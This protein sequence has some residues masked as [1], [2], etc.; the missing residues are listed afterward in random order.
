VVV[1][2][3]GGSPL[4]EW[5]ADEFRAAHPEQTLRVENVGGPAAL[6]RLRDEGAAAVADVWL[7]APTWIMAR[8]AAEGLLAPS[9]PSW[10]TDLPDAMRDPQD[11]WMGWTAD[12]MVLAFN[13]DKTSRSRAPRDWID[14]FHPRWSV[15]VL[16]PDAA[17]SPTME[18]FVG[19][20]VA[21]MSSP[22]AGD[23]PGFDWLA[24]LDANRKGYVAGGD[25]ALRLGRGEASLALLSLSQAQTA[26]EDGGPVDFR[27]PE[28]G[29]PTLVR[30]V[31]AV[32]GGPHPA[33]A[34]TFMEWLGTPA[35]RAALTKRFRVLPAT[36]GAVEGEPPWVTELRPLLR[37]DVAPADTLAERLGGWLDRW[38]EE[39]MG[40]TPLVF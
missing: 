6:G 16:L 8:A 39:V 10:A 19:T 5:L 11:R 7:G 40:R 17:G 38:H 33:G 20:V 9:A 32:A 35:V 18:A 21:L 27:V 37:M 29:S 30:G 13:T 22:A 23:D 2:V 12:P 28:S 24:R 3:S 25:G 34:A 36:S 14:L 31:A 1:Y 4:A 26:K 15:E